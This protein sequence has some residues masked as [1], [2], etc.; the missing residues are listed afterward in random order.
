MALSLPMLWLMTGTSLDK[1]LS[2]LSCVIS[3]QVILSKSVGF[4]ICHDTQRGSFKP[5]WVKI[6]HS[7]ETMV[8]SNYAA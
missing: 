8:Y 1:A 2:L 7:D 6:L 3:V 5:C 4:K